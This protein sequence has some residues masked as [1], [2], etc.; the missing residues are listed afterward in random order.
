[1]AVAAAVVAPAA[2][3]RPPLPSAGHA[4]LGR[5][6]AVLAGVGLA[7]RGPRSAGGVRTAATVVGLGLAV[8]AIV[9]AVTF[10]ASLQRLVDTPGATA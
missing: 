9:A 6:P 1:M 8:V 7:W 3:A 2:P 4:P 5:W 10:Q